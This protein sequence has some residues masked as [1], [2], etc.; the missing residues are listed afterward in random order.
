MKIYIVVLHYKNIKDTITC[1]K[2]ISKLQTEGFTVKVILVDNDSKSEW[3]PIFSDVSPIIIKN[4]KNLGFAGGVNVG[5]REAMKDR[6]CSHVLIL[7]N[8][9][10]LP[11][12]L[13]IKL[14]VTK[15]DIIAPVIKFQWNGKCKYDFGGKINWNIGRTEHI[16]KKDPSTRPE[17]LV[18]MTD[19]DYVSGCCMLVKREVFEKI[20]LFDEKFFFYFEDTDFCVRAKRVGFTIRVNPATYIDHKLGGAIGRWSNKAIYYNL[21]SNAIFITKHLG[22]KRPLGY[23][24][25]FLLAGKIL[26]DK[27]I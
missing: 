6:D 11:K 3:N 23:G 5:I 26:L 21:K 8:D 1:L 17:D 22:W 27:L 19:V 9:T 24:Y 10:V 7:N 16:E 15:N 25:L 13:I 4:S 12:D 2:S 20:G 18:G 14:L